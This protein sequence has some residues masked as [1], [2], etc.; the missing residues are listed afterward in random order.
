MPD[1]TDTTC[2]APPAAGC[3]TT[4]CLARCQPVGAS[5]RC[6]RSCECCCPAALPAAALSCMPAARHSPGTDA[7]HCRAWLLW[8]PM[9]MAHS[10][11]Q[12][13]PLRCSAHRPISHPPWCPHGVSHRPLALLRAAKAFRSQ[14][15]LR[16]AKAFRS[17]AILRAACN[18]LC[19]LSAAA[20][21]LENNNVRGR[22][23][24]GWGSMSSIVV[25]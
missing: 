7:S 8:M 24:S 20:R 5:C 25:M 19:C 10:K 6:C 14:A 9:C 4:A 17:Q 1:V 2:C 12:V 22:M 23:P 16:A 13:C 18:S 3:P 15:L 21:V 11:Q